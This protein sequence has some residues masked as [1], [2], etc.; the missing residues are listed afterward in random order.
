[1]SDTTNTITPE[2]R[3]MF[4]E[5]AN[6]ILAHDKKNLERRAAAEA[7]LRLLNALKASEAENARLRERL[8]SALD[9]IADIEEDSNAHTSKGVCH[10]C[11]IC[12]DCPQDWQPT[13]DHCCR[14]MLEMWADGKPLPWEASRR[15]VAAGEETCQK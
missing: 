1:M 9:K 7:I 15:A 3:R 13:D 2:T 10:A 8:E 4:M 5:D 11:G 12:A 14:V 6:A